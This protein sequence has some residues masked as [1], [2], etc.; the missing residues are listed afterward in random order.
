MEPT[1]QLDKYL[2]AT[3]REQIEHRYY[4]QINRK[5]RL[6]EVAHDEEFLALLEEHVVLFGDHGVVHVRDVA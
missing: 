6:D 5:S 3:I 2:P 4:A 1:M